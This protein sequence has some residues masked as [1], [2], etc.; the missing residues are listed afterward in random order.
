MVFEDGRV[1]CELPLKGFSTHPTSPSN[2]IVTLNQC[3]VGLDSRCIAGERNTEIA[4][5]VSSSRRV[6]LL[7]CH[8]GLT[9]VL[10]MA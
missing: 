6:L 8:H 1:T 3:R 10:C 7:V 5:A 9:Q 4:D 2:V